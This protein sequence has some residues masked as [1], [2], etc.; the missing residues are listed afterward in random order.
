M[1]LT[2]LYS[3]PNIQIILRHFQKLSPQHLGN[4][5]ESAIFIRVLND[6]RSGKIA[7]VLMSRKMPIKSIWAKFN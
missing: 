6:R 5:A 4:H 3:N 7:Q 1:I 2:T